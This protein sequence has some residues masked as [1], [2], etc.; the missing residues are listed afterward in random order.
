[1]GSQ[2]AEILAVEGDVG[3]DATDSSWAN[4]YHHKGQNKAGAGP[5]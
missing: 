5:E 3:N 4:A 2:R 1:M